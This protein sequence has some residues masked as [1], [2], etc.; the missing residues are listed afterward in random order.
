M[1]VRMIQYRY[2]LLFVYVGGLSQRSA[3]SRTVMQCCAEA[4]S[5]Y[6][7]AAR[8]RCSNMRPAKA[9]IPKACVLHTG[10]AR[11]SSCICATFAVL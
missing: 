9:Q 7:E 8:G 3:A 5:P 4:P 2:P 1:V 6:G 10:K 11:A